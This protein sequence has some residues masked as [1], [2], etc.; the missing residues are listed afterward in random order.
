MNK[1]SR[2][3]LLAVALLLLGALAFREAGL[4]WLALP[5]L[6]YFGLGLALAPASEELRL[7]ARRT[8]REAG[9]DG[10]ATIEVSASLRNLGPKRIRVLVADPLQ[11]GMKVAGGALKTWASLGPGEE[12]E[13][14]YSFEASR[15]SFEWKCLAAKAGDPFGLFEIEARP[16]AETR[17]L[18]QPAYRSWRPFALR[19]EKTLSSP[20]SIPIRLGGGGTDFWGIREYRP[21]DPLKR[22]YW[23]LSARNPL[24]RYTKESIQERTAEIVLVLDGRERMELSVGDESLFEREL[25]TVASLAAMLVRQGQRVGLFIL[26]PKPRNV[27]PDYGRVQLRR[28]LNCLAEAEP[29]SEGMRESLRL[30]PMLRYSRSAFVILVSPFEKDDAVILQRLRALGYQALLVSPDALSFARPLIADDPLSALAL[31]ACR[32]E[33]RIALA[34]AES[35]SFPVV[36]WRVERELQPLLEEAMARL[37]PAHRSVGW[38][39]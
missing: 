8:C 30:L 37:A 35:L 36:D 34:Q 1:A 4:A 20:G 6:S 38:K 16:A 23:R 13:L 14:E 21:G 17:L 10:T 32:V 25:E 22:L 5:F 33:R 2:T 31:A 29:Q 19:L 24:R 11:H 9:R 3:I 26:G 39:P 7:S 28:I 18:V 15:G 12:A 27:L